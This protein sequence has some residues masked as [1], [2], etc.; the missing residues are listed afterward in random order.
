MVWTTGTLVGL[1]AAIGWTVL[2]WFHRGLGVNVLAAVALAGT[3]L[4]GQP[5]A[6]TIIAVV[7]TGDRTDIAQPLG[8]LIGVDLVAADLDPAGKLAAGNRRMR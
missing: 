6:G 2:G 5:L 1:V 3:L 4:I 7:A 8:E